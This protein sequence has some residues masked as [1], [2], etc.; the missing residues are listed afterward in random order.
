MLKT[1]DKDYINYR[2]FFKGSLTK[3]LLMAQRDRSRVLIG[4]QKIHSLFGRFFLDVL[5]VI[6][7]SNG[8]CTKDFIH[9]IKDFKHLCYVVDCNFGL[10]MATRHELEA[11]KNSYIDIKFNIPT[12]LTPIEEFKILAHN[13]D[14]NNT[15]FKVIETMVDHMDY[16]SVRGAPLVFNAYS[17]DIPEKIK[18]KQ[19]R[20]YD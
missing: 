6:F 11:L 19:Y 20:E 7:K 12:I 8:G 10:N 13:L 17:D 3:N 4:E 18:L 1:L 2:T 16:R 5:E 14:V 9:Y 15:L